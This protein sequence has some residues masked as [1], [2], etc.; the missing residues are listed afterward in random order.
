MLYNYFGNGNVFDGPRVVICCSPRGS[1]GREEA[2]LLFLQSDAVSLSTIVVKRLLE[3]R[4]GESCLGCQA[5]LGVVYEYL[6]QQ[7][8]ELPV[9]LCMRRNDVLDAKKKLLVNESPHRKTGHTTNG[10]F[11][12]RPDIF[13]GG[14]WRFVVWIIQFLALEVTRETLVD[15][16]LLHEPRGTYAAEGFLE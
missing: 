6:L 12:H 15:G 13:S 7:I 5:F 14:F 11:L 1:V 3:P 16:V 4:M 9:E 10:E 8:E 2:P